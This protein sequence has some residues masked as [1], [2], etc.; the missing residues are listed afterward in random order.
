MKR[1]MTKIAL[2]CALSFVFAGTTARAADPSLVGVSGGMKNDALSPNR[3]GLILTPFKLKGGGQ[4][5]LSTLTVTFAGQATYLGQ[6][7]ATGLLDPALGEIAGTM[8]AANGDTVNWTGVFQP[9]PDGAIDATLTLFRGTGRFEHI[10][11][12]TGGPVALDEDFMFTLDLEGTVSFVE[13]GF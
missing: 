1:T 9:G 6:F 13:Q 4:I 12:F 11:G 8:T 5:D 7:T 3:H 2:A 10:D